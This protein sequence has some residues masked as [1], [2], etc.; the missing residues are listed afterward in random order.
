MDFR[1][2]ITPKS[3]QL[4]FE[5]VQTENITARI[6]AVKAGD[7]QQPIFIELDG[8]EGRAYK[9]SKSMRRVL[10]GG[11][12][13]DG[14]SWVGKYLELK[15]D[16]SVKFGGVAV[17][18]IKIH[19]M[20]DIESNFSMMLTESRGRRSE[21]RVIALNSTALLVAE[22]NNKLPTINCIDLLKNIFAELYKLA[23]D[24]K[25][26][27]EIKALYDEAKSKLEKN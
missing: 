1:Q 15:G 20:S 27:N 19:G 5:D 21:H 9:P 10:I 14:H 4:N 23:S 12:G 26:K 24:D 16:K 8:Y 3:D 13:S 7:S 25:T 11:W 6:K 2:T 22:F 18:G 17:G